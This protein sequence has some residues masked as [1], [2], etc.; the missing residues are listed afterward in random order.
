MEHGR[1]PSP[2]DELPFQQ[3]LKNL[4]LGLIETPLRRMSENRLSE[5]IESFHKKSHPANVV[6]LATLIRGARLA[7][8]KEAFMSEEVAKGSLTEIE[9]SALEREKGTS[10]WTESREIKIVL[11]TCCVASI[12]QGWVSELLQLPGQCGQHEGL[13]RD[14]GGLTPHLLT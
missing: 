9:K 11:L 4:R 10:I 3:L 12:A 1:R 14:L 8:D 6:D 2:T 13:A 5:D 7:R